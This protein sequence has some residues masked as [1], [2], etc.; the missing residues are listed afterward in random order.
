MKLRLVLGPLLLLACVLLPGSARADSPVNL[1]LF[2]PVQIVPHDQSIKGF[3]LNILYGYNQDVLGLDIGIV[4]RAGGDMR[5]IQWIGVGWV[6]GKTEGVQL[7]Y[8]ANYTEEEL[9]G[10]QLGIINYAGA[11]TGI[12]FGFVNWVHTDMMGG[13]IGALNVAETRVEGLQLGAVNYAPAAGGLQ[14]SLVNVTEDL[15]GVQIGLVNVAKN[16]FLPVFPI[17]NFPK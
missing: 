10:G 14:F 2:D 16:G 12:S 5:G 11:E 13:Q 8:I 15:Q 1:A 9:L 7:G 3:R 17:V 4:N 6:E